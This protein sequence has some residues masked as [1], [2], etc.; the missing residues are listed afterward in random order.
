MAFALL[1]RGVHSTVSLIWATHQA[2]VFVFQTPAP[3][4]FTL[5]HVS[6]HRGKGLWARPL[7]CWLV[8]LYR[9]KTSWGNTSL[10]APLPQS[11][12]LCTF[13]QDLLSLYSGTWLC[14]CTIY[15]LISPSTGPL[16]GK[17]LFPVICHVL[18]LFPH[19]RKSQPSPSMTSDPQSF[20]T[21]QS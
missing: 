18:L 7:I 11:S 17:P 15:L 5:Y 12:V 10:R 14:L 6:W 20:Y 21:S 3:P 16:G 9:F 1:T 8:I 4:P 19:H 13:T 2:P